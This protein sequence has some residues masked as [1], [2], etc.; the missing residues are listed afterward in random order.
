VSAAGRS[1]AYLGGRSCA[2]D[3]LRD[4]AAGLVAF[5]GQHEH[6]RLTLASAQL[7]LLDGAC[8]PAS[9]TPRARYA[10]QL[11]RSGSSRA[12]WP[13]CASARGARDRE[14]DLLEF[15]L[16]E[17][18]EADPSEAEEAELV[19]A[20]GTGCATSRRCAAAAVRGAPR[21]SHTRDGMVV[22]A[23]CLRGGAGLEG[24]Q[25]V[26]ARWDGL[27]QRWLTLAIEATDL[28]GRAPG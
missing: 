18:E 13:G 24:I 7:E 15:E 14:I 28:A 26:D 17:I 23:R 11:A 9:S 22:T 25:G 21:R 20:A 4:V 1:R 10:A 12:R 2:A 19:R 16:A 8:G 27:T 3:E 5:Y 6:R